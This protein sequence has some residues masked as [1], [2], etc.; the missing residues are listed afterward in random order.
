MEPP[1]PPLP[2]SPL[3]NTKDLY[4]IQYNS[5]SGEIISKTPKKTPLNPFAHSSSTINPIEEYNKYFDLNDKNNFSE[6]FT[7]PH[8]TLV[9]G[10]KAISNDDHPN[11]PLLHPRESAFNIEDG[12]RN[13]YPDDKFI[14]PIIEYQKIIRLNYER[15]PGYEQE[16]LYLQEHYMDDKQGLWGDGFDVTVSIPFSI[17]N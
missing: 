14:S 12:A 6:M 5:S 7:I 9:K 11:I 2:I 8:S 13:L 3:D 1:K 16:E 10:D 15:L 17:N 4:D